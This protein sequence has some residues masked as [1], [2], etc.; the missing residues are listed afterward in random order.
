MKVKELIEILSQYD[1]NMEVLIDES[2]DGMIC[3]YEELTENDINKFD[4][5]KI[6][7]GYK[8]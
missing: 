7:I 6:I 8:W 2:V 3:D 5:N 4:D 1:E